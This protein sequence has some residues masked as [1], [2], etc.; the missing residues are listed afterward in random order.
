[1]RCVQLAFAE[2]IGGAI[3]RLPP[4]VIHVR[5]MDLTLCKALSAN[6][7]VAA[8][9][10]RHPELNMNGADQ[11]CDAL[12]VNGVDTAVRWRVDREE[13]PCPCRDPR[14]GWIVEARPGSG[15]EDARS[16]PCRHGENTPRLTR[17]RFGAR[18]HQPLLLS[19][20]P[21]GN[22]LLAKL[23]LLYFERLPT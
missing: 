10:I 12:L 20:R 7:T 6:T 2:V 1:M 23:D 19:A 18:I 13:E 4:S 22:L 8:T 15:V 3:R 14:S 21:L 5:P 9:K 16:E 11:L 17:S